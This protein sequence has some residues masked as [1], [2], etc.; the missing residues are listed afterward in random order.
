MILTWLTFLPLVGALVLLA[1][2]AES[3]KLQRLIALL[4]TTVVAGL[5]IVLYLGFDG[6][7]AA[8]QQLTERA[9]FELPGRGA[10]SIAV[11]YRLGVDGIS[12]LL[13]TLTA[14]L[15]PLVVL[16]T[17]VH[18]DKRVKEFMIWLLL[19][20]TGM[21]GVFL[22]LDVVL[23]Y[24]FWELSLIPLYFIL[25]I[26]GGERRLYATMKFFLYTV[27]GSLLMMLGVIWLTYLTGSSCRSPL[28]WR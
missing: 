26:W 11:S 2:P 10:D 4:T 9:W 27:A 6:S 8:A 19:M 22:S 3:A 28:S 12:I 1:T 5:G 24:F 21:L 16:S 14:V 20:E 23:F 17:K 7:S 13:V 15:M 25:G 18:I